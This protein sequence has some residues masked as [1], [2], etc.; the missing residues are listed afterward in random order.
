MYYPCH[1]MRV[2]K[3][4][5]EILLLTLLHRCC[6]PIARLNLQMFRVPPHVISIFNFIW[7][8]LHAVSPRHS[9]HPMQ[10]L[11]M[12]AAE[13]STAGVSALKVLGIFRGDFVV[14]F[15]VCWGFACTGDLDFQ[16]L[17]GFQHCIEFTARLWG[18]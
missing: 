7:H 11:S 18:W 15:L 9:L 4:R 14:G 8:Q 3:F 2:L 12:T 1:S 16:L 17:Q 13:K 10:P 6:Y 5:E